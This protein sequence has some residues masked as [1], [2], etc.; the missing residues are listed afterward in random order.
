KVLLRD[1]QSPLWL[2]AEPLQGRTILLHS[3]QGLGDTLQFCRYAKQVAALGANVVLEVPPSL[4]P[5]L[6]NLDGAARVLAYGD[7]LPLF[8]YHCPLL[9]LPLAFRT[10]LDSIPDG[11]PYLRS[12]AARVQAWRQRLG[13]KT[14]PRI[15][16]VWSG[17]LVNRNDHNRSVALTQLLPLVSEG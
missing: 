13:A 15:G 12:D 7:T 14:K 11:V 2:G 9:S 1:F 6:A 8:A 5:L 10:E 16:L 3:E 17:S 4:Q